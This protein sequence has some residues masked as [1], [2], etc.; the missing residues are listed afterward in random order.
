MITKETF[1][2]LRAIVNEFHNCVTERCG[3]K[4]E[5]KNTND[6]SDQAEKDIAELEKFWND[7][8]NQK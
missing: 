3:S 6:E 4:E 2:R 5:I 8:V 7:G 1:D